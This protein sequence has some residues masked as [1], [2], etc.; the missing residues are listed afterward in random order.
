[1]NKIVLDP[2][3]YYYTDAIENFD[4]FKKVL[5][6][7]DQIQ[8][9]NEFDVNVWK[10]WTSSND[11]DFIYGETK[12]FDLGAIERLGGEV[13]EKSKYIYDAITKAFYDICKDYASEMGDNDEPNLFPTFNIKKYNAGMGMGAHFD[14]L[15]GDE[16]LRYSLVMYLNDDCEGGEISFQLKDYD[17]GWN[18]SDGWVHGAP[19]VDL[20]YAIAKNDKSIDFGLKPTANSVII[21]PAKAPYFHTAHIVK[22]GFKYMVPGHWIHNNVNLN[23]STGM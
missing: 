17:G 9:A 10:P 4:N 6:E 11:K 13:G 23:R 16:T 19:A 20:D 22:S 3:T 18:S 2:K 5:D 1:M 12:T 7:L 14:Q 15:D 21:F 8:I